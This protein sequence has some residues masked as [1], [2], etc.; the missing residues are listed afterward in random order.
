MVPGTC[1]PQ[2]RKGMGQLCRAV[3][4]FRNTWYAENVDCSCRLNRLAF[5]VYSGRSQVVTPASGC[6]RAVYTATVHHSASAQHACAAEICLT[7]RVACGRCEEATSSTEAVKLTASRT[8]TTTARAPV[9]PILKHQTVLR[10]PTVCARPPATG[11]HLIRGPLDPREIHNRLFR[12]CQ[13]PSDM[14][15]RLKSASGAGTSFATTHAC[16]ARCLAS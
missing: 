15:A 13:R 3:G 10:A 16:R 7:R 14:V 5:R 1:R 4:T 8:S 11:A 6:P 9:A 2:L 12:L